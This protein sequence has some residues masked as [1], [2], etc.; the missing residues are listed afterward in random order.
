MPAARLV[1]ALAVPLTLALAMTAVDLTAGSASA[2]GQRHPWPG[3]PGRHIVVHTVRSGDTVTGL[4]VRF[5]AWT[6]ELISINHLGRSGVIRIGERLRIPVVDRALRPHH[7]TRHHKAHHHTRHHQ[8]RHHTR[9]RTH[10]DQVMHR[11]GWRHYK[12]SRTQVRRTVTHSAHRH[13]VPANLA[14]AIAW[15]ESGWHQPLVSSAGAVGVMQLLP[16]TGQ[17]MSQYAGR[18][19]NIRDTYDNVLGGVTLIRVLRANTHG[20]KNAVAAYYQGLGAVQR[21][22]WYRSTKGYVR[23]VWAIRKHLE[24]TGSPTG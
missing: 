22:G 1:T 5:H 7:R 24:R 21:H 17:W 10:H 19:L 11:R 13:R 4:A 15:Q 14:L 9:H 20:D 12:L 3:H 6:A 23:S 16:S 18:R 2:A 8:V